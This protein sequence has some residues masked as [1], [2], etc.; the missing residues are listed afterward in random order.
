MMIRYFTAL[1]KTN[2]NK[3]PDLQLFSE[4]ILAF[5][6]S[7]AACP[8]CGALGNLS[9]HASYKRYLIAFINTVCIYHIVVPRYKC[10]SC[11]HTHAILP[12]ILI[13]Y[14]SYSL[15]FI[16]AVL[17]EHF[18]RV[19]TGKT[20]TAICEQ[21]H[22]SVSTLYAFKARFLVHKALW[23]GALKAQKHSGLC[24]LRAI[25]LFLLREAFL[26]KFF[27][28]FGFSFLQAPHTSASAI[29]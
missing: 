22:I 17:R 28:R 2:F 6:P 15:F 25:S 24:F 23:L 11:G 5:D 4:A 27:S 10:E 20:V 26:E 13:P 8:H 7:K 18:F 1:F 19:F 16:F 9:F 29:P 14:G 21:Y 12:D 3:C